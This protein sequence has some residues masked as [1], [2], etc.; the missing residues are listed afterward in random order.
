[1]LVA[2]KNGGGSKS[3]ATPAP[4][5]SAVSTPAC[6]PDV[7]ITPGV[8]PPAPPPSS[9]PPAVT[10]QPTTTADG[11]QIFDLQE[12]TGAEAN[13]TSCVVMSYT[14][15]LEDGTIFDSSAIEGGPLRIGLDQVIQGWTEGAAG[16]KVG[17]KRRLI[18]PPELAYGSR[19]YAPSIPPN[20]TLTFDIE[21][22]SVQ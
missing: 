4:T 19:G 9:A 6:I 16:M 20:A 21:L 2:C 1:M 15:W 12:G 11:L 8:T 18:I 13:A 7:V 5:S 10:A 22:V 14:G 17:G 3:T